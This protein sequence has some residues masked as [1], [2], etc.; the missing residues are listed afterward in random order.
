MGRTKRPAGS[1]PPGAGTRRN[2]L[3]MA[4]GSSKETPTPRHSPRLAAGHSKYKTPSPVKTPGQLFSSKSTPDKKKQARDDENNDDE[5]SDEEKTDSGDDDNKEEKSSSSQSSPDP[6]LL[7][8]LQAQKGVGNPHVKPLTES[9][10]AEAELKK[11][12]KQGNKLLLSQ[13]K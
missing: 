4:G 7:Q 8:R 6:D 12:Y 2:V 5:E 9:E 3:P 10:K 1:K 13:L 11:S